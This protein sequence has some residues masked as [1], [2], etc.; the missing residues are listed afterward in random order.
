MKGTLFT[1]V[2]ILFTVF[3]CQSQNS[4]LVTIE[5]FSTKY[6]KPQ[7]TRIE[8]D[9]SENSEMCGPGKQFNTVYD[10]VATFTAK[11]KE[12]GVTDMKFS[13]IENVAHLKHAFNMITIAVEIS[14]TTN[15]SK[16]VNHA[17]QYAFADKIR[18]VEIYPNKDYAE[19]DTYAIDALRDAYEKAELLKEVF[20]YSDFK[21]KHIDDNTSKFRKDG[22][23]RGEN[24]RQSQVIRPF[25]N[26]K[27]SS[28][29]ALLVT[30]ELTH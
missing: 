10:Q 19:E 2:L 11:L 27:I 29:Y 6:F 1:I 12:L 16:Q 25:L 4:K 15:I 14:D 28:R 3:T 5:G 20:G 7:I 9:F 17:S 22:A 26:D 21:I 30:F 24:K 13:E 23:K 18:Y 8:L